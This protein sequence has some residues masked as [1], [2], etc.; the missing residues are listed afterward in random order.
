MSEKSP[1]AQS[2][3]GAAGFA[4]HERLY[5]A[6][7][8]GGIIF[9]LV[10]AV[11]LLRLQRLDELPPGIA[12]D[13]GSNGM[14]A[15]RVLQGEHAVFYPEKGGGRET[16]GFYAIALSIL[17]LGRT[18]LAIHLP[19][20]LA[21]SGTILVV[22]W[23]G[24]L[25]FG[26]DENGQ[27]TP[28]RGL[29]VGGAGAGL[30]AV[31]IG[32][33]VIGRTAYRGNFLPVFL[34]LCLAL[35]WWGWPRP[36]QKWGRH[37]GVWWRIALA[38]ACAGLLLYTYIPARFAP[39]LFFLFGLS[40]LLPY[41][42]VAKQNDGANSRF[43]G[44]VAALNRVRIELPWIGTFAAAAALVAAPLLIYFALHPEHFILRSDS[45]S[46]FQPDQSF[47][48]QLQLF[49]ANAWQHLSVLGFRG[50]PS[51]L[52]NFAGRP[53]LNPWEAF[54]FWLGA[55]MAVWRW[56]RRPAYRLLF[57]WTG[58]LLLP[59]MLA[60]GDVVPNTMRMIGATPAIYLL[61]GVGMWEVFRFLRERFFRESETRAAIV[62]GVAV[63]GVILAQGVISYRTYFQKWAVEPEVYRVHDVEWANLARLLNAQAL[64]ADTVYLIPNY[65]WHF[66]FEYLYQGAAPVH[67]FHTIAPGLA[68]E[69]KST[70]SAMENLSTVK[71]VEW[72]ANAAW[73][74]GRS[75]LISVFLDKYGR[76]Q[77]GETHGDF[78]IHTYTDVALGRPWTLYD[79]LEPLTVE[80]DGGIA[81]Q[82]FA[83]GQGREQLLSDQSPNLREGRS[84]WMALRW[85]LAPGLDIDYA[86]SLRLHDAGGGGVYQKDVSLWEPGHPPTGSGG[87]TE[88]F[89][90]LAQLYLPA[91]LQP[92]EYELRLVVYDAETLK[93]T[94]ELGVWEPETVLARLRLAE[95]P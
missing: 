27:A 58:V 49:L 32:Q 37:E 22:F 86:I 59:A 87:P 9:A 83:L 88:Q 85:Q 25:F 66:G 65:D 74:G 94:V 38:G 75:G 24:R 76:I 93:P 13:E 67:V 63:S 45:L 26:R 35:L 30:L 16:L 81:L 48:D 95:D 73:I 47:G 55:G 64:A 4:K 92:G 77:D 82:G 72:D 61:V 21:S 11:L 6:L 17:F 46:I 15:L 36:L 19:S 56:Q 84:L 51:W 8:A 62:M 43:S 69:I 89:E 68:Q 7:A 5:L 29:L 28:W 79:Q 70:L 60:K 2:S 42:V 33:T 54:F 1:I 78:Q 18:P 31:S 34:C 90:T 80:Y 39:F 40:F 12:S 50:D 52:H 91:D 14:D 10:I 41:F 53:M 44:Y 71:V 57:L 20:A 3:N 23:L